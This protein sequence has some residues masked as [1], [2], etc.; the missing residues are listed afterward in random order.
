MLNRVLVWRQQQLVDVVVFLPFPPPTPHYARCPCAFPAAHTSA[1]LLYVDLKSSLI[2]IASISSSILSLQVAPPVPSIYG[3]SCPQSLGC[4]QASKLQQ[5]N[6]VAST[7]QFRGGSLKTSML[8]NCART[9]P[10]G[11]VVKIFS[12]KA[13]ADSASRA[14]PSTSL[15]SPPL[16]L[17]GALVV[18]VRCYTSVASPS[19]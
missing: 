15:A 7:V 17:A 4:R 18:E 5:S 2:S 10:S 16:D 13:S 12:R 6:L 19:N 3:T 9:G 1:S 11:G 8:L 14:P